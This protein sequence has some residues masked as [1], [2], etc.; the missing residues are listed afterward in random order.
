MTKAFVQQGWLWSTL[1]RRL[2][3]YSRVHVSL[4]ISISGTPLFSHLIH[5]RRS[6]GLVLV[7]VL[8]CAG[9]SGQVAR[10]QD[11]ATFETRLMLSPHTFET[12]LPT[13]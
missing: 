9:D 11:S 2:V 3:V 8:V 7:R 12:R 5:L 10:S 1:K 6:Q 13:L 4:H